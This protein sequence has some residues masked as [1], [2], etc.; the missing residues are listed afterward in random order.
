ML[1]GFFLI[2]FKDFRGKLYLCPKFN[3]KKTM[4]G[5]KKCPY[6][7]E[8]IP[9]TATKCMYC[10]A[11]LKEE[12]PPLQPLVTP[13]QPI[14]QPQAQLQAAPVQP[15]KSKNG[16]GT[17]GLVLSILGLA[18]F[19]VP[20]VDLILWF[21]GF[22]FS[23]IGMFKRPKGKAIAGLIISVISIVVIIIVYALYGTALLESDVLDE[24]FSY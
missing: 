6:C 5:Y 8:E 16:F 21:L 20:I 2:S 15:A 22:L 9:E 11:W 10:T 14:V 7:G 3:R 19:W 23:F 24:L 18:L 12:Q 4:E 13:V 17:A 1:G